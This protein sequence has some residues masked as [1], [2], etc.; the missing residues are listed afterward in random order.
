MGV[1]IIPLSLHIT[2]LLRCH[3]NAGK[4]SSG[5]TEAKPPGDIEVTH[6]AQQLK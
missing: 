4:T 1:Q 2:S 3:A 6:N 5:V